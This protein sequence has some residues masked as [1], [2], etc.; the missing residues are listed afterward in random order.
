M[1]IAFARSGSAANN[2]RRMHCVVVS[3]LYAGDSGLKTCSAFALSDVPTSLWFKAR[4]LASG[5]YLL[6]CSKSY[7]M[8]KKEDLETLE[9]VEGG[10]GVFWLLYCVAGVLIG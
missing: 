10:L 5:W 6:V 1:C 9:G 4:R 7:L 8:M 3:F 2:D